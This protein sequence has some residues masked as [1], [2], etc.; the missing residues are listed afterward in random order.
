M[1]IYDYTVK[2]A[3]GK[4]V[5]LRVYEGKVLLIVNTAT[6][7]GFTPQYE[8]LEK[9]Y[10]KYKDRGFEILDFPC[11]QFLNQAPG[12]NEEIVNFCKTNYNTSFETFAK[13]EVN[14]ENADP[15]YKFL[16]QEAPKD[17]DNGQMEG[18]RQK[19]KGKFSVEENEIQ[20]NF[21]K[22]LIDRDGKV[23]G[24]FAPTVSP[25]DLETHIEKLL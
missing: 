6:G 9:L 19:L 16:K 1:K 10:K 15:L 22:F 14:G 25:E 23:V 5:S 7:C 13:I 24:R 17:I 3:D 4:E 20:W 8:G 18:L 21:T 2:K 12:T 11:N